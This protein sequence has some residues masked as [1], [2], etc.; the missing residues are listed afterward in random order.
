MDVPCD[1]AVVAAVLGQLRRANAAC[2]AAWSGVT[3]DYLACLQRAREL[4]A[5]GAPAAALQ[6]PLPLLP[7][8]CP[9]PH[10]AL[11]EAPT[12]SILP[13]QVRVGQLDKEA[14]E[15]RA[16]NETLLRAA[17]DG[18]RAAVQGAMVRRPGACLTAA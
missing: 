13:C 17:E 18:K 11:A 7:V 1:P 4:Q 15:L 10:P 9:A 2:R 12:T 5:R 16:E 14:A 6:P 8:L 3:S